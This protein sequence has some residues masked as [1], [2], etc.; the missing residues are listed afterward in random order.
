[1]RGGL[2]GAA[3][4]EKAA[5]NGVAYFPMP[6]AGARRG[7][8]HNMKRPDN[9]EVHSGHMSPVVPPES[10]Y[11]A[12]GDEVQEKSAI[13]MHQLYTKQQFKKTVKRLQEDSS[14]IWYDHQEMELLEYKEVRE[15]YTKVK[16]NPNVLSVA[17]QQDIIFRELVRG[18]SYD[19]EL[20][21]RIQ[22]R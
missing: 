5:A 6:A 17:E 16:Q 9:L 10:Q 8:G 21:M 3:A 11:S 1:M 2:I 12:Q 13:S 4:A 15:N 22:E 19:T 14:S 18:K 20:Q 7:S